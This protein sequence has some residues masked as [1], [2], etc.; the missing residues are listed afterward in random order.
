MAYEIRDFDDIIDMVMEEL[1]YQSTD[2][3]ALNRI[4][5]DI[6]AI[7]LDEVIPFK[8]WNWLH[9]HTQVQHK[10]YYN[11]GTATVTPES[12]T[13]TLSVAPTA[14]SG[15]RAGYLFSVD[16]F[17]E[18]YTIST[19]TAGSTTV[20]L[21]SQYNGAL[22][23]TATFK[24]WADSIALPTNLK[25]TVEIWQDFYRSTMEALGPQEFRKR[26]R[27]SPKSASKPEYYSTWDYEFSGTETEAA[28]Y[29]LLKIHPSMISDTI[30]LHV[31]YVKEAS[32]LDLDA[33]EPLMPYEDRIV[34]VYGALSRAWARER[35]PEE[36]L[37]NE[38]LFK[39]KL[40]RMAGKV[41]DG[42]DKPQLTPDNLYVRKKRGPRAGGRF[43]GLGSTG[44]SGSYTSPTY[45]TNATLGPGN[46]LSD[47]LTVNSG[48]TI[49]GVDISALSASVTA[50]ETLANGTLYI[51]NASNVA[52]EQTISGDITI[53]NA[54]VAAIASGVIENGDVH[55]SAAIARSKLAVGTAD[56]VVINSG[57]GAFSSEAALSPVRGGTGVANNAAATLTRSGNHAV[58][59][60]TTATTGVTLP[61]TGTLATLAGAETL[62]NK[63]I[64][65]DANTISNI[66]N[67]D[68]KAAAAIALDKLAATTVTR[69][70][71][72]DASGFV[73]P[74]T[75]TATE[76]GFINGLTSSAQTQL[77]ARVAK[78]DFNAK[79]DLLTASADNTPVILAS[80]GAANGD[81]LTR[82]SGESVGMK[83]AAPASAPDQS[84]EISNLSL[85]MSV[86]SSALTIAL[87]DKAGSDP[88][89]GSSVKI[90]FRSTTA[91]TAS[92]SQVTATAATSIVVPS[93]ATL[94]LSSGSNGYIFV[95]AL[96]NAGTIELAV[97]SIWRQDGV[98]VT[99]TSIGTGSD[100]SGIYS[101]TGRT[102]VAFRLIGRLKYNTA[103]NGTYSATPDGAALVTATDDLF[104][105]EILS[106]L[107]TARGIGSATSG[108]AAALTGNSVVL[109][110]GK[111]EIRAS[112]TLNGSGTQTARGVGV[113]VNSVNGDDSTTLASL[114]SALT[115]T[116]GSNAVAFH[117]FSPNNEADVATV[118]HNYGFTYN[119]TATTT[120][121]GNCA[122]TY[123]T[124]G[125]ATQQAFIWAKR[126][127]S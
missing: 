65:A 93:T 39:E 124:A 36:A 12:T 112:A 85:A 68:I 125:G 62:T 100:D 42:F 67:A 91:A 23:T 81:V 34:L 22:S 10:A 73:S 46:V 7:Y 106:A 127:K 105:D 103:P 107:S 58:T 82:D 33:D 49:D 66:E 119:C 27:M 59:L 44:G 71:V 57:T 40:D 123:G 97:S 96:N 122:I 101:T 102:G 50:I 17:D 109:Q 21:S 126:I 89:A 114:G 26:V 8:R 118:Q 35:N 75:T 80:T 113:R 64:D 37:R 19:H 32:P 61:T 14:G 25:E 110:P 3:T 60:T 74:A 52:T 4:K 120:I 2:T 56:H 117:Q 78:A 30:T 6:N 77:D 83:W 108:A 99:T 48:V 88:S 90:G 115:A 84:Y 41:E 51:G 111:Y 86:G 20:V 16:G 98:I 63:V 29:R 24:I 47:N 31:D 87:K 70:L 116:E 79:G 94:G 54:G 43:R 95:Y 92:Y 121:Y 72:S 76:I 13:V 9:G 69:A 53:S 11:S 104:V 28:R 15:S 45:I 18:I 38:R 1:K 5:R 55:T